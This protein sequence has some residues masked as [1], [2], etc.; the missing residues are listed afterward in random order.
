[1]I[2]KGGFYGTTKSEVRRA[3]KYFN[4]SRSQL[5]RELVDQGAVMDRD[6]IVPLQ[7]FFATIPEELDPLNLKDQEILSKYDSD[8]RDKKPVVE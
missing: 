4:M 1:M 8:G 3:M 5:E 2:I 7:R 6:M